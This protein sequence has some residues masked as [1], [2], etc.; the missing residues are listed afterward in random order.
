M[1][2][3]AII[4]Q[5]THGFLNTHEGKRF[6]GQFHLSTLKSNFSS[7]ILLPRLLTSLP[8]DRC[9]G[10]LVAWKLLLQAQPYVSSNYQQLKVNH[11]ETLD[12]S[13]PFLPYNS[14]GYLHL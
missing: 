7:Y 9:L 5:G 11:R 14:P 13:V 3:I 10:D 8:R 1:F 12:A 4:L 6:F 2:R